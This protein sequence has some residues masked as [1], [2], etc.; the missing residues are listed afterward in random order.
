MMFPKLDI[1]PLGICTDC[2]NEMS[3]SFADSNA[4]EVWLS[5]YSLDL[6]HN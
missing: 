4:T 3:A 2:L 5:I 1:K 6:D